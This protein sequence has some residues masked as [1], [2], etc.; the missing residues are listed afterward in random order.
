MPG[1]PDAQIEIYDTSE[2]S[3]YEDAEPKL[4]DKRL[5]TQFVEAELY[6]SIERLS[7][8]DRAHKAIIF[9]DVDDLTLINKR[10]GNQAGDRVL[11]VFANMLKAQQ[12][13]TSCGRCGDDTFFAYLSK[14]DDKKANRVSEHIRKRIQDFLW[15]KVCPDLRVRCTCGFSV[16]SSEEHPHDWMARAIEGMLEGKRRGGNVVMDGPI[17]AGARTAPKTALSP[18]STLI[19]PSPP[20]QVSKTKPAVARLLQKLTPEE[21][22]ELRRERAKR[23]LERRFSLRDY[24]S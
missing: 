21:R 19:P 11:N 7:K 24:F 13:I 16:M 3:L 15:W 23:R 10:F 20:V 17:L 18:P 6:R 22:K 5:G 1:N 12:A 8:K 14:A 9:I 2:G 4:L